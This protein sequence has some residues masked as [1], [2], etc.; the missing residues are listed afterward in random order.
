M[1]LLETGK[2]MLRALLC[3]ELASFAAVRVNG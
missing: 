1:A 2:D 3:D